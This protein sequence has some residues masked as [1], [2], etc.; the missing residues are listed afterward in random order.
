MND[1]LA[2]PFTKHGLFLI[3]DKHLMH[4][5][6]AQIYEKIIPIS[7]GVPP[8]SDQHVQEALA[9]SAATLQGS[10]N[11]GLLMGLNGDVNGI[12]ASITNEGEGDGEHDDVVM[13]NPLAGSGWSDETYQLVLQVSNASHCFCFACYVC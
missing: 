6:Q 5:R 1:I 11:A 2:K 9:I 8:L 10:G 7:V 13:R 4:L 3:L 12:G